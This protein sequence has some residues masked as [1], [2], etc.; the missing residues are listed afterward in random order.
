MA[1]PPTERRRPRNRILKLVVD[2]MFVLGY[3]PALPVPT[4]PVRIHFLTAND[5][6][7]ALRDPGEE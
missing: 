2:E 5:V 3:L 7:H 1:W 6:A 4:D